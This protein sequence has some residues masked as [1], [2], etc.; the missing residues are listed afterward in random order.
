MRIYFAGSIRGSAP[1]WD[2]YAAIITALTRF[3][4]V[5]TEHAVRF[6]GTDDLNDSGIYA[7]Q[8][9]WLEASDVVV[10]EVTVPS[11]GVGYEI[12]R[13]EQMLKPTLCLYDHHSDHRL[14]AMI[15]GNPH[16]RLCRYRDELEA[17]A[18]VEAFL[19]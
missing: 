2:R 19:T 12:A 11:L 4:D 7:R 5:L 15:A 10:A 9:A 13:A 8:M 17:I 1:F 14:S 3:G 16:L 6:Q 18:A